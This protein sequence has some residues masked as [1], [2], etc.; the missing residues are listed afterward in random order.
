M[1]R[2]DDEIFYGIIEMEI[3]GTQGIPRMLKEKKEGEPVARRHQMVSISLALLYFYFEM[4]FSW[5]AWGEQGNSPDRGRSPVEWGDFPYVRTSIRP[6]SPLG[7]PARP[8][9]QS[10]RPEAQPAI[11]EA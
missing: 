2:G 9:A 6:F 3:Q 7:H 10:A 8:E 4:T 5:F 11:P 1:A